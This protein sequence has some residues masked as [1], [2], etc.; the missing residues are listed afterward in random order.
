MMGS[1][2]GPIRDDW[3]AIA[4]IAQVGPRLGRWRPRLASRSVR[5]YVDG[6]I[7]GAFHESFPHSGGDG[8]ADSA[9]LRADVDP[10]HQSDPGAAIQKPRG[11]GA[12]GRTTKGLQGIA[13]ADTG[14]QDLF[15]SLGQ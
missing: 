6:E 14:R 8:V 2:C 5:W 1:K 7:H 12:G 4:E 15:R 13:E 9:G 10:Q 3:A 11:K